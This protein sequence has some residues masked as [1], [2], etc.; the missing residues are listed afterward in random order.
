[1]PKKIFSVS[2]CLLGESLVRSVIRKLQ[3]NSEIMPS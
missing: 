3:I 1:M 2:L